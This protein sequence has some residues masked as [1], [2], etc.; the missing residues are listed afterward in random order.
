MAVTLET[1]WKGAKLYVIEWT[2]APQCGSE[3]REFETWFE[4]EAFIYD[5]PEAEAIAEA[6]D[7]GYAWITETH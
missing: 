6:I 2:D 4:L 1:R 5:G 7:N 3:T